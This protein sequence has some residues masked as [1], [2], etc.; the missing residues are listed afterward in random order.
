MFQRA[1][2]KSL[3]IREYYFLIRISTD[4]DFDYSSILPEIKKRKTDRQNS[5]RNDR[6]NPRNLTLNNINPFSLVSN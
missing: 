2:M 1:W 3:E 6:I 4:I 5:A